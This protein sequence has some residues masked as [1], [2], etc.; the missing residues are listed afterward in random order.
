MKIKYTKGEID[1]YHRYNEKG[2][3]NQIDKYT[4]GKLLEQFVL[5]EKGT[6][7]KTVK[8]KYYPSSSAI[9][10]FYSSSKLNNSAFINLKTGAFKSN[11]GKV[12]NIHTDRPIS[13]VNPIEQMFYPKHFP[14]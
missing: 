10:D 8:I 4:N 9:L 3:K 14:Y 12:G 11:D 6:W 7:E 1:Y 13:R 2:E 5:N